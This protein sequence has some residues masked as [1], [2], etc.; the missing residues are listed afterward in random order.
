[1]VARFVRHTFSEKYLTT[2]GVKIDSK[3]IDLPD[4]L[5]LKLVIWDIAGRDEYSGTD[6]NYLRGSAGIFFVVDGTRKETLDAIAALTH[7]VKEAVGDCS[8]ICAVN[9]VDLE[10]EWE[11]SSADIDRIIESGIPTF[12]TSAKTGENVESA[13]ASLAKQ[14]VEL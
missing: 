4:S 7:S 2:V 12:K 5:I 6:T 14:L 1:M 3:Q 11:V 8:M 9:K 13:F 10:T